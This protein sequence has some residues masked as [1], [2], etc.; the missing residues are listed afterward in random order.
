MT[1]NRSGVARRA[2]RAAQ[3]CALTG[4]RCR[5][6]N[7]AILP[8]L[9]LSP[10]AVQVTHAAAD[11]GH[12]AAPSEFSASACYQFV[13]NTGRQIAWARWEEAFPVETARATVLRDGSPSWAID[14]QNQ[15][16]SDAYQWRA[17]DEQI[18]QWAAELGSVDNLPR[19]EDLSVHESIA[20][21]MRRIGRECGEYA[22]RADT[23][24]SAI[25]E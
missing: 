12:E 5:V 3:F 19:A 10:F 13:R 15:W 1:Q 17:S 18:R 7:T 25:R 24:A 21:W 2:H 16:I 8:G 22:A 23:A 9:L 20:I 11:R 6:S 4:R 14:L